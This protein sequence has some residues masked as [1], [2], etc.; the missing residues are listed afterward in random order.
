M[1]IIGATLT[2]FEDTFKGKPLVSGRISIKPLT[3]R[4]CSRCDP[5]VG[6]RELPQ[7]TTIL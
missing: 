2:P 4:L 5:L 3:R 7:I 6:P 1:R